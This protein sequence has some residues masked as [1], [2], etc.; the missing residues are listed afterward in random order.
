MQ[1]LRL[2][3][4]SL[5][6]PREGQASHTHVHEIIAGLRELGWRVDLIATSTGGAS[7]GSS[8]VRRLSGYIEAQWRLARRLGKADAVYIRS[9]FA[10][11][12]AAAAARLWGVPVFQEVNGKPDD[13]FV[14]YRRFGWISPLIRWFYAAQMR[15][16]AHVF[17]VTDGLH[18]WARAAAGHDRIS[19]VPNGANIR[20]FRPDGPPSPLTGRYVVFV[21]GLVRWHGVETMIAARREAAWPEGVRLVIIGDGIERRHLLGLENDPGIYAPGRLPQDQAVAIMRGALAALC[22]IEDPDGRSSTGVAPLKLFESMACGVAVIV[23]ELPFQADLVRSLRAG[24]VTP[25]SDPAALARAVARL[26][27]D[28]GLAKSM[29]ANGAAYVSREASWQAR[30]AQIASVM[31]AAGQRHG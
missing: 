7:S 13:L 6:T 30:A 22:V 9:H 26:A 16:A 29:G 2:L 25:P 5:E 21:G 27:A 28:P 1:E 31:S 17:V 23:S 19:V 18:A 11:L 15:M 12:P 14:T 24:I 8:Y 4:L 10:A 20:L 3:Y